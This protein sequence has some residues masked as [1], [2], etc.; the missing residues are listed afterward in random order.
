MCCCSVEWF[1]GGSSAAADGVQVLAER[2]L[3]RDDDGKVVRN[4]R[5]TNVVFVHIRVILVCSALFFGVGGLRDTLYI[6][7]DHRYSMY[8]YS[9]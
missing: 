7:G 3:C 8:I 2:L 6:Y 4:K 9:E 5:Y 1:S